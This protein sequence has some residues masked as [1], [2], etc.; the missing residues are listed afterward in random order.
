MI[1]DENLMEYASNDLRNKAAAKGATHVVFSTH[2]MGFSS[3]ENGGSTSTSTITGIA[4]FCPPQADPPAGA[5]L[6]ITPP[7][8]KEKEHETQ[9][10]GEAGNPSP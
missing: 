5:Q 9:P 4:Y 7:A 3:G 8:P 2:Q 1:P 6:Q 10:T